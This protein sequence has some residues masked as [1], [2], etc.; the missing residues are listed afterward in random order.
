MTEFSAQSRFARNIRRS[1]GALLSVALLASCSSFELNPPSQPPSVADRAQTVDPREIVA[2]VPD[3]RAATRLRAGAEAEGFDFREEAALAGLNLRLLRFEFP[4]PLDGAGAIAALERIEPRSTAGVNH[5]YRLA[6]TTETSL[7]RFDY[8]NRLLAWPQ[9]GCPARV[10]IGMIDTELDIKA[11]GARGAQVVTRSFV[12]PAAGPEQHGT[13]VAALLVDPRRLRGVELF[14]AAVVARS[15]R[16]IEEAGVDDILKA[17]DWLASEGVKVVN[18]SLSGPY[19]KLLDRGIDHATGLGM[20]L[21]AAVG[22]DGASARPRYPAALDNVIAVTAVDAN[23]GVYRNAVRGPHVDIAA[24]GVDILLPVSGKGR[25]VTGTS[26]AVPFVTATIASDPNMD[27]ATTGA[28]LSHL[29]AAAQDLGS[30]GPDS[31]FGAGL[32]SAP[33]QC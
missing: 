20:T 5:A 17:L 9:D 24:P 11:L 30:P 27:G 13:D 33:G 31:T 18:I 25:F 21:V 10:K 12:D 22:N 16:G 23:G 6:Q 26:M 14:S 3:V 2:L 29:R 19:N 32:L 1:L 4:Q 28:I 7:S 8:A 15:T